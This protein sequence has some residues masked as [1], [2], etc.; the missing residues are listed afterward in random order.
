[1]GIEELK[2]D[3][4]AVILKN[5]SVRKAAKI[6]ML[7]PGKNTRVSYLVGSKVGFRTS[8]T[9]IKSKNK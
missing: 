4:C 2:L 3:E 1:M 7:V 6:V 5:K 8:F 9:S